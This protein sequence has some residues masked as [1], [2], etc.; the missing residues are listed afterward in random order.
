MVDTQ[1]IESIPSCQSQVALSARDKKKQSEA[2]YLDIESA[3]EFIQP[4][5]FLEKADL[6]EIGSGTVR[7]RQERPVRA[8][9]LL[10]LQFSICR[11]LPVSDEA[12]RP[13]RLGNMIREGLEEVLFFGV[14]ARQIDLEWRTGLILHHLDAFRA[15]EHAVRLVNGAQA[16]IALFLALQARLLLLF[17]CDR[18]PNDFGRPWDHCSPARRTAFSTSLERVPS[19]L[20]VHV[21]L[22]DVQ[23]DILCDV[24]GH[25]IIRK[26]LAVE[27]LV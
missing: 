22:G 7:Q 15:V 12:R 16:W 27:S 17:G 23:L 9:S 3:G 20:W 10:R 1:T 5:V 8:V 21:G 13:S 18:R 11:V 25:A 14:L 24:D 4:L 26:A 6:E 19:H 2:G